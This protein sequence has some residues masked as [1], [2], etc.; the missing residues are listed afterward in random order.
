MF[1]QKNIVSKH[2]ASVVKKKNTLL[3]INKTTLNL[4]LI[5]F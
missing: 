3:K 5:Y 2:E 4:K 1:K